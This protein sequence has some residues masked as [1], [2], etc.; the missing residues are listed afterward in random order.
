VT[1]RPIKPEEALT[2]Q[3]RAV[4]EVRRERLRQKPSLAGE[5]AMLWVAEFPM[6]DER[7]AIPLHQLRGSVPL[8]MVTPVP[9]SPPHVVGV[10]RFQGQVIAAISLA[11]LLGG[12]GWRLDPAVLLVVE[13]RPGELFAV[14]A[15]QV[16]QPLP[17]PQ[18]VVD[19]ARSRSSG[20]LCAVGVPGVRQVNL[21]DLQALLQA[22]EAGG[23]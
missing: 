4:L 6:G 21:I 16:P 11:A 9:L 12:R 22:V 15:E 3:E 1:V 8:K 18:R 7:F 17:I 23:A 20:P 5:E 13:I 2:D 14:D 10:V 19:A